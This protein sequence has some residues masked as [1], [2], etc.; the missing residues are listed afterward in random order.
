MPGHCEILGM[1][2]EFFYKYIF[3]YFIS[4]R[5]TSYDHKVTALFPIRIDYILPAA[6]QKMLNNPTRVVIRT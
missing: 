6:M 3:L 5:M 2:L 1:S 4:R